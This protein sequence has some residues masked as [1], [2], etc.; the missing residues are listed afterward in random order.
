LALFRHLRLMQEAQAPRSVI[1]AAIEAMRVDR[2]LP[3]GFIAAA[4]YAPDFE[5]ELEAASR[6][7]RKVG[8]IASS[9][10]AGPSSFERPG[11]YMRRVWGGFSYCLLGEAERERNTTSRTT[12]KRSPPPAAL[13]VPEFEFLSRIVAGKQSMT[14][15]RCGQRRCLR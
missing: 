14:I 1:A 10:R 8:A 13:R 3:Y 7:A 4:R 9:G 11:G 12:A 2:I 15:W 5:R 6:R